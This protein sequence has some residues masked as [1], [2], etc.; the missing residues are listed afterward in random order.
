M[1]KESLIT[2]ICI[3]SIFS[4]L[5]LS[6]QMNLF[7]FNTICTDIFAVGGIFGL[8]LLQE[9]YGRNLVR[10]TITINLMMLIFYQCIVF[11]QVWYHPNT[12][13]TAHHLFASLFQSTLRITTASMLV[14]AIVQ[15]WD[16]WFFQTL[17]NYFNNRFLTGRIVA[18]LLISQILD[19]T[20]FTFAAL[21]GSVGSIWDIIVV[22]L[23][24]KV[25]TIACSTPCIYAIKKIL[26]REK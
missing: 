20:L 5:L 4:N 3:Q 13:D 7:G 24:I 22:S 26:P 1:G 17:K 12:F 14:Y 18:S 25:I 16:A 2:I 19:T 21:Y 11:F 6:K 15:L 9:Y 23:S 10:K 8:N